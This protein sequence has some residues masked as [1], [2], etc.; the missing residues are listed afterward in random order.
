MKGIVFLIDQPL[1]NR[2]FNRFG[3]QTLIDS[4]L[5]VKIF[6]LTPINVPQVWKLKGGDIVIIE[7][8]LVIHSIYQLKQILNLDIKDYSFIDLLNITSLSTILSKNYICKNALLEIVIFSG[9][10]PEPEINKNK[11][12][13][14]KL[15]NLFPY[16]KRKLKGKLKN[17]FKAKNTIY[18]VSGKKSMDRLLKKNIPIHNI[19]KGHNFDFDLYLKSPDSNIIDNYFLFLD[20]DAPFHTDYIYHHL[21]APVTPAIYYKSLV[22]F[23]T[24]LEKKFNTKIK[25]ALHP[26][27]EYLRNDFDFFK[28]FEVI[29]YSTF[30]LIKNCRLVIAHASTSVQLA[31]LFYKPVCYI[32]TEELKK[33]FVNTYIDLYANELGYKP[34]NI[35]Q[36]NLY[37]EFDLDFKIDKL[38]YDEYIYNYITMNRDSNL[39][40]W[41]NISNKIKSM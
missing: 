9:E 33:S 6:D 36:I 30:D 12:L 3:I 21:E 4:G 2:N 23:F 5:D 16:I 10:T 40:L 20:E 41:E 29:Q 13:R 34:I 31:V 28:G 32:T 8:Y 27:S 19:F 25:I 1:D 24:L 37:S 39:A 22:N 26:R 7:N 14:F 15:V 35:N 11:K 17:I 38:K 18:F